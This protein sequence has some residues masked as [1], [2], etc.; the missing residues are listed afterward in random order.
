VRAL[1]LALPGAYE[2]AAWV[3]TRWMVRKKNFAHVVRI[4]DGRPAAYA[5]AAGR[6]GEVLTFRVSG[7]LSDALLSAGPRFFFCPWGTRWGTK[8]IGLHLDGRIDWPEVELLVTES[9][10]LLAPAAPRA[11]PR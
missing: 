5:K 10:R 8:V 6:D 3:G 9:H 7:E 4:A 1:C 2:E 11:A